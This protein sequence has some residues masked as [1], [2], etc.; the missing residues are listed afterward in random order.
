MTAERPPVSQPAGYLPKALLGY[1]METHLAGW[2][3]AGSVRVLSP[4]DAWWACYRAML[5]LGRIGVSILL[6]RRA[7]RI[8][9][10]QALTF[11]AS[12]PPRHPET[13]NGQACGCLLRW[14]PAATATWPPLSLALAL[15]K[16]GAPVVRI[17]DLL[18]TAYEVTGRITRTLT[19]SQ[20]RWLYPEAYGASYVTARDAYL[21]SGPV[22]ALVLRARQPGTDAGQVKARI[23][24]QIG[25]GD[26][27]NHL[28]M[29]G[30]PGE[31][32][33]DIAHLAGTDILA[34]LYEK[35]ERDRANL[36]LAFYRAA[37]GIADPGAHRRAG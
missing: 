1:V 30:N 4:W 35:H 23:R 27:R 19:V 22:T 32:L 15:I 16:P 31:A 18:E 34:Q 33:A 37:L 12:S 14:A 13:G 29:P 24:G 6:P 28:H 21:T 5:P 20:T 17:S 25:A 26:L 8:C 7:C 3:S 11:A 36:R 9:A 10:H 2:S